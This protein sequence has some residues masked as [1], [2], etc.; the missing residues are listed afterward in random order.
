[1]WMDQLKQFSNGDIVTLLIGNKCDL[2]DLRE[3]RKEEGAE[4]AE[5]NEIAF[6]ETS[7]KN[8]SNVDIAFDRVI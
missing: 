1:M 7:A 5:S 8:S 3:V 4:F 2:K 6:I